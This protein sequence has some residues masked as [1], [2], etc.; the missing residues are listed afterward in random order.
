VWDQPADLLLIG[1]SF[2][3]GFCVGMEESFAGP[4][5]AVHP[6]P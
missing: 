2:T 5:R 4:H 6:R 1:D 3:Q